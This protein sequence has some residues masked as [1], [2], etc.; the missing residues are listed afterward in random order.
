[1]LMIPRKFFLN[2]F[3]EW[4][5]NGYS[6][7]DFSRYTV[8]L[9]EMP[10]YYQNRY[11]QIQR[12]IAKNYF[13]NHLVYHELARLDYANNTYFFK[14]DFIRGVLSDQHPSPYYPMNDTGDLGMRTEITH[15]A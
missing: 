10:L 4:Q 13:L 7:I 8:D 5:S 2:K 6:L 3:D 12:T 11:A 14:P 9:S 15:F 1:M